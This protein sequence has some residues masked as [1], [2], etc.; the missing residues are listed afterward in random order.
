V[1]LDPEVV[2]ASEF[3]HGS[4]LSWLVLQSPSPGALSRP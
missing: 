1:F 4:A 3:L 2:D